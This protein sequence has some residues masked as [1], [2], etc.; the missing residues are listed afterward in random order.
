M[1]YMGYALVAMGAYGVTAIFLKVGMRS[2]PA[3]VTLVITN[4]VL[5]VAGV[6]LAV[7]RNQAIAPHLKMGWPLFFVIL[8]GL[9]LSVS[10]VSYYTAL[11]RGPVSVVVPIFG[12][13]LAV[14]GT[15]GILFLGEEVK[16]TR[17]VGFVLAGGSI[18]LMTR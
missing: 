10:I 9:T 4:V 12:M 2:M 15:L 5:V 13:S 1:G 7:A 6:V 18:F 3:E 14:A 11:S 17:L 16:I 8:A